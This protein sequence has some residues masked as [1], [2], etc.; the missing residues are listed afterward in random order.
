MADNQKSN[1][2]QVVIQSMDEAYTLAG[3]R[4]TY[5]LY[6]AIVCW[7][8]I[9]AFMSL[10]FSMPFLLLKPPLECLIDGKFQSCTAEF[11]CANPSIQRRFP[12]VGSTFNFIT[13]FNMLCTDENNA[14]INMAFFLGSFGS[15]LIT[16]VVS[17]MIGRLPMLILANFGN[18]FF[19]V[20]LL[21]H[22]SFWMIVA[23]SGLIGVITI[24]NNSIGYTFIYDSFHSDCA[25]FYGTT[26][27]MAWSFGEVFIALIFATGI[28]WRSIFF[29]FILISCSSGILLIWVRESPRF[30]YSK[31]KFD[32]T[33]EILNHIAKVNGV[34]MPKNITFNTAVVARAKASENEDKESLKN[35]LNS[36]IF[37]GSMCLKVTLY[38]FCYSASTFI[39][40]AISLNLD[41]MSGNIYLLGLFTAISEIV[42]AVISAA[43]LEKVGKKISV[44]FYYSV[45]G[46]GVF[47]MGLAWYNPTGST[48]FANI[49]KFG[50]CAVDNA[51]NIFVAELFPTSI[52]NAA[53]AIAVFVSR[54]ANVMSRPLSL[55]SP[56]VMCVFLAILCA[57]SAFISAFL[58]VTENAVVQDF[59]EDT[60]KKENIDDHKSNALIEMD[61]K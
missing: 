44:I 60:N 54:F 19:L 46:I 29:I 14:L 51:L 11:A 20:V 9:F 42:S 35:V 49:A 5:Q 57:S 8:S 27:T 16:G 37:S 52:K 17:D 1:Q 38:S 39:Y 4:G 21:I 2:D 18:A 58:P 24:G 6:V 59:A 48:V 13:E 15:C 33:L 61:Q 32:K 45:A 50:I 10:T 36:I 25:I 28:S 41:K 23:V 3:G 26:V 34:T 12:T 31:G 30:Y 7:I 40:Y 22:P 56:M 47:S 43:L 55:L 53:F